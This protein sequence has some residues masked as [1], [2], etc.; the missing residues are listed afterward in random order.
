M[1]RLII[2]QAVQ[3]EAVQST[4]KSQLRFYFPEIIDVSF[5]NNQVVIQSDVRIPEQKLQESTMKIIKK[6]KRINEEIPQHILFHSESPEFKSYVENDLSK[7]DLG[8]FLVAANEF[9][10][11]ISTIKRS[12]QQ[13]AFAGNVYK[14]RKGLNVYNNESTELIDALDQFFKQYIQLEYGADDL[15]PPSMISTSV[16]HRSGYFTTGCQH[17]SFVAPIHNDPKL[18]EEF[19]PYW[20]ETADEQGNC[21]DSQL[22]QYTKIP[23]DIL[24]PAICLHAYPMFENKQIASDQVVTLTMGGSVFRDESGNLNNE[25]R[26]NEFKMREGIFIGNPNVLMDIHPHL[27]NMFV[28][29]GILFSF[30]FQIETANDMFF[31]ENA[32]QQLLTQL[33]TDNKIEMNVYSQI[34]EKYIS[35]ASLNKHHHH[36]SKSFNINDSNENLTHTMCIAFGI[37]RFVHLMMDHIE[38]IGFEGYVDMMKQN[39]ERIQS[40]NTVTN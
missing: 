24:N 33:I 26:L 31:D 36:F 27:L 11:H 29:C 37:N 30:K 22:Y 15:K 25:Y 28:L 35:I 4:L 8:S 32:M 12:K 1:M 10:H 40:W 6:F 38:T 18:F 2:D 3:Q 17:I 20:K 23:K 19:L 9:I 39:L 14:L 16:V 34:S 7:R 21:H 13:P 5:E